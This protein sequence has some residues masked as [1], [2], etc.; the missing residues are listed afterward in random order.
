MVQVL[1]SIASLQL[2]DSRSKT[3]LMSSAIGSDRR[4]HCSAPLAHRPWTWP[5]QRSFLQ[6][7]LTAWSQLFSRWSRKVQA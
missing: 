5:P 2:D 6:Y 4:Q 7:P 1:V 3:T